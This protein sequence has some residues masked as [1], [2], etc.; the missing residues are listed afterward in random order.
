[1][2]DLKVGLSGCNTLEKGYQGVSCEA[3]ACKTAELEMEIGP[4]DFV[5]GL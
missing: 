4:S 2:T 1:M 3:K 5:D